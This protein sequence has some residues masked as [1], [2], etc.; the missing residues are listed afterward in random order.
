LGAEVD[1][2][3]LN[4]LSSE[5]VRELRRGLAEHQVL[6]FRDQA[7]APAA[8]R[9]L[10][11][12]LGTLH[13]H[14]AYPVAGG[15]PEVSIL[16]HDRDQASKIDTWHTDMTFMTEPTQ[17]SILQA[18]VVPDRGGDTVFSSCGAAWDHLS[19]SFQKFLAPLQA[20]H[21]F[22]WGFKE[23]LAEPGGAERLADAVAS[24]PPVRHGVMQRHPESGRPLL[25]VNRL[26]TSH[27]VGLLPMESRTILTMLFSHAEQPE[28]TVRFSWAPYSV[29][30]WDNR[31]T[32]HRPINDHGART[33][34]MQ[35]VTVR[36]L[37]AL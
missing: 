4:R 2:V 17:V 37:H 15:L 30:I 25:Y 1:D 18:L 8:H 9:D 12:L 6:F 11:L 3:S 31:A 36:T 33:R 34:T 16:H 22:R 29:A 23:S 24:F 27:I 28:F 21:D 26:F 7:L 10:G 14:P 20:V 5:E 19:D 32:W 35:R 13:V